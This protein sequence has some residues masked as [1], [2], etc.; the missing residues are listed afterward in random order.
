[1]Y[2]GINF[3]YFTKEEKS[4]MRKKQGIFSWLLLTMMLLFGNITAN[5]DEMKGHFLDVGQGLSILVQCN[6]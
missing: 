5:A 3:Y 2:N 6:G 4:K 1:M